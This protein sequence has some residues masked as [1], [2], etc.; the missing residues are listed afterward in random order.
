MYDVIVIGG[1]YAGLSAALQLGRARRSVLVLDAGR[2][3]NRFARHAHGFLGQDG[4]SPDSIAA[5]GRANVLAYSTVVLREATVDG[6]RSVPGGFVVRAGADEQRSR[7]LILATGVVDQLPAVPG[8]GERW[9][10]TVFHCP[11]CHGYEL[12]RGRLGVL[13][14]GPLAMHSAALVAEWAAPGQ[15][16][17]FLNGAFEPDAEQLAELAARG[18]RLEREPVARVE[19]DAP[20]VV[21]QLRDGRA[22]PLDGL[23][24]LPRTELANPFAEELGCE[25]ELGPMGPFYRVDA[26]KETSVPGVFACGDVAVAA[27]AISIA[28]ADGVLA[29]V[30]AHRSL[31][32]RPDPRAF[33]GAP[34][35]EPAGAVGRA[36]PSR[37]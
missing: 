14:T 23:F 36:A 15:L 29:G 10:Q 21:L 28:V 19:G 32:F 11:Y 27:G 1:S 5:R 31:V 13:A 8:L 37:G 6:I 26:T 2:R 33:D 30:S 7:R 20:A 12:G 16:T 25:L 34:P 22:T 35:V 24:V 9:G 3:R 17:L 4:E 18:I